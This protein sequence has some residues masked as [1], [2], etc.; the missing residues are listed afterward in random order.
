[1]KVWQKIRISALAL[2]LRVFDFDF[3]FEL[4]GDRSSE[5][6]GHLTPW[7]IMQAASQAVG[8]IFVEMYMAIKYSLPMSLCV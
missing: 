3:D 6:A 5:E 4:D 1:L 7:K 2:E 8:R